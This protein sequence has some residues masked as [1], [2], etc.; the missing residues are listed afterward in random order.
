[1]DFVVGLLRTQRNNDSVLVVVKR[2]TNMVHF[3]PSKKTLD[4]THITNLYFQ[5][6]VKLHGI[7]KT[8]VFIKIRSS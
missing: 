5:E 8:I 6:I 4:E 3:I 2:F 7:S 1:M